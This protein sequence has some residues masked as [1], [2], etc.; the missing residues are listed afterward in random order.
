MT[1]KTKKMSKTKRNV[2]VDIGLLGIFLATLSPEAT[3]LAIHEWLGISFGAAVAG[4]IL[5]HWKWVFS[6]TKRIF[7]K[8]P[9]Q[10]RINYLLNALLLADVLLVA[11]S[12]IT[13][14][15]VAAPGLIS[16]AGSSRL[17][18]GIHEASANMAMVLV[19]AH[20]ALHW[21]W[22][23]SMLKKFLVNP[24]LSMSSSKVPNPV[25]LIQ[26]RRIEQ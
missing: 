17:W 26:E 19:G 1:V 22:I 21:R 16:S 20:L 14:S 25:H 18:L 7:G 12:G 3:G 10:A 11:Y 8:L 6:M 5:L 24:L 2:L 23:F 13:I 9:L 15:E 4:H